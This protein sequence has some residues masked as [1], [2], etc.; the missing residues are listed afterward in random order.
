M[1]L[2]LMFRCIRARVLSD[3]KT[4]QK[5]M[6]QMLSLMSRPKKNLNQRVTFHALL[7]QGAQ[8]PM[9]NVQ[10]H[11]STI[12]RLENRDQTSEKGRAG[13]LGIQDQLS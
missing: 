10:K 8:Q 7:S 3:V 12:Q 11:C 1:R 5:L 13:L 9:P 6:V 2:I 4:L